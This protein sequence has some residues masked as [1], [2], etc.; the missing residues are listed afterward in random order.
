MSDERVRAEELVDVLS[1]AADAYYIDSTPIMSDARYD[2]LYRELCEIERDHPDLLLP[3]SP[4]HR[5]GVAPSGDFDKIPHGVPM[6]SLDNAM[7]PD[8]MTEFVRKAAGELGVSPEWVAEPKI[9]GAGLEILYV[10]GVFVHAATRGDGVTGEDVTANAKTI[11]G[12]PLRL[13]TPDGV[14]VPKRIEIRG[15]VFIS[16]KA[17]AEMNERQAAAGEKIFANPRNAASGSLNQQDS[18]VTASRPLEFIAYTYGEIEGVRFSSQSRFLGWLELVGL[19]V[20]TLN[21]KVGPETNSPDSHADAIVKY[22]EFLSDHREDDDIIPYDIDGMVVKIDALDYQEDLGFNGRAPKWAIAFKFKAERKWTTLKDVEITTGRTGQITPTAVFEVV[23]LGGA[24][25]TR[26]TLHNWDEIDRLDIG[27]GDKIEVQKAG[28]VI[29][30]VVSVDHSKRP[31]GTFKIP[32]PDRCPECHERL[33]REKTIYRCPN[34]IGCAG[35]AVGR[36][37]HFVSRKMMN[38][39]GLGESLVGLLYD[40]GKIR[41]PVDIFKLTEG[42][43]AS[44]P[45]LGKKSAKKLLGSID[46]A[47]YP[48]LERFLFALGIPHAGQ[49]TTKR[50]V[51]H[52]GDLDALLSA[53]LK[54]LMGIEDIG[55]TVAE[56]LIDYFDTGGRDEIWGLVD[57]GV[58]P[59]MTKRESDKLAG[60]TFVFTGSLS[61]PRPEYESIVEA[62]GGKT[63][64]S[65]GKKTTYVV[66]GPGAGSKLSKAQ[67]LGTEI[68]DEQEFLDL[69]GVEMTKD[70]AAADV[71]ASTPRQKLKF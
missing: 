22:H 18:R 60:T 23:E 38:I 9:D 13:K 51:A 3:D 40:A 16:H 57:A 42:D 69:V 26:A 58:A 33:E 56:S 55:Q 71:A 32:R 64:G 27:I 43:I 36:L 63:S 11:T 53:S 39:D 54:D 44:L 1:K 37:E 19:P 7:N 4:S 52:F 29:P 61:N 34:S 46:A 48:K 28:D 17:F 67:G 49:G 47:R 50:L 66:A 30:Q 12:I 14:P 45:S 15:E 59:Q 21:K 5:V 65:V 24:Q 2:E 6:L 25:V 68:L 31:S 35:Q 41:H 20:S 8:E 70:D 10:D 62:H